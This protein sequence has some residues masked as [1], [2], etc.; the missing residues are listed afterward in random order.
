M[1]ISYIITFS[2]F[3]CGNGVQPLGTESS[4]IMASSVLAM[5]VHRVHQLLVAG[6]GGSRVGV[7]DECIRVGSE[8]RLPHQVE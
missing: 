3:I 1:A 8:A 2:S 4:A 6:V 7:D 5:K